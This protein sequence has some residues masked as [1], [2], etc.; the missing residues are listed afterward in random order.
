METKYFE[1]Q[2]DSYIKDQK[3]RV[4]K[5][6][7]YRFCNYVVSLV[8]GIMGTFSVITATFKD[9]FSFCLLI[10]ASVVIIIYLLGI[11]FCIQNSLKL[12]RK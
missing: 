11:V 5:T 7:K 9:E 6:I 3:N 1:K 8:L 2:Y 4:L 12:A 10:V